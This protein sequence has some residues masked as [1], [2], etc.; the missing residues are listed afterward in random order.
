MVEAVGLTFFATVGRNPSDGHV[1]EIFLSNHKPSSAA[2]MMPSDSAVA[3]SLALPFC[4]PV[5][6]GRQAH[7]DKR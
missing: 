2:G 3:A 5:V 4:C 1:T 6:V 7:F